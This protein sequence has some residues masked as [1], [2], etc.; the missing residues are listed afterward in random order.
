MKP[1]RLFVSIAISMISSIALAQS[2]SVEDIIQNTSPSVVEIVV[3]DI[4]GTKRGQGSG[5]F[6]SR[7]R[8]VTNA[9]VVDGA[10]S[11]EVL[12]SLNLYEQITIT[13]R[14]DKVD[15][16]LLTVKDVGEPSLALADTGDLRPGQRVLAIGN[17]LGL[18]HTVS[19]GLISA[20][21]GI[22]GELQLIQISAPISP[23]SSGGPLLNLKGTVIGVTSA[24]MFE[25]QNLN[26]AIGIETLKQFLQMPDNS[27]PLKKARTRVL[28]RTI[29]KW[30]MNIVFGIFAFAFG[31][32]WFVIVIVIMVLSGLF[33]LLKRL[34][35]LIASPFRRKEKLD[36]MFAD[37]E[38]S[39][40]TSEGMHTGQASLFTEEDEEL[41][42]ENDEE[43]LFYF[44]CWKC[45]ESVVADK[46]EGED[47]IECEG[48]GTKLEIPNEMKIILIV[49]DDSSVR[50]PLQAFLEMHDYEIITADNGDKAFEHFSQR[51]VDLMITNINM[52]GMNGIELTQ[53]VTERYNVK[54]I[55]LTGM[56]DCYDE[57]IEAG[58]TKYVRKPVRFESFLKLIE[59]IFNN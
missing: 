2:L 37:E 30:V 27:E 43:P 28:W 38:S 13:K 5:F 9:H 20:V 36:T 18:E 35:G 57:A 16:A 26:F 47:T 25:G 3:Y 59:S 42:N 7:G 19:D 40:T 14:N 39:L 33:Y 45:G 21:R 34:W 15:L 23:G 46:S 49:D 29:L 48:C 11:A 12:S 54:V 56:D 6:I 17:P 4:T 55:V 41:E 58:A 8:I 24:S 51:H 53:H 22:P 52:P 10:Y 1:F 32:G 50:N 44:H 31:G